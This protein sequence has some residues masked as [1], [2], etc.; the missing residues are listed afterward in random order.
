LLAEPSFSVSEGS[1]CQKEGSFG[2]KEASPEITG[3]LFYKKGG[4]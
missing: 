2:K 1:F 3:A 4:F